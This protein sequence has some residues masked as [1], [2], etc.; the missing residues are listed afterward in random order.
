MVTGSHGGAQGPFRFPNP[1]GPS[2]SV[3]PTHSRERD[4]DTHT[5]LLTMPIPLATPGAFQLQNLKFHVE[6]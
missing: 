1:L 4:P 2:D 3:W 5:H 6:V